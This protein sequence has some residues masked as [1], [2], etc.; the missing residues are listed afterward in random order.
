MSQ[1]SAS[2]VPGTVLLVWVWSYGEAANPRA[3]RFHGREVSKWPNS[4]V[5]VEHRREFQQSMFA[6]YVDDKKPF[7]LIYCEALW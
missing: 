3:N 1:Y 7:D 2:Q 4:L 6:A 5:Q